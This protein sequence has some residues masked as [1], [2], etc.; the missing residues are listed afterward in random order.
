M[1]RSKWIAGFVALAMITSTG[2][3]LAKLNGRRSFDEPGV[4]VGSVP[5][6][7]ETGALAAR[8]SVILPDNVLG[9]AF[10][11]RPMSRV[12]L[13]GLPRDTTFGRR[14]Y[15]LPSR[16]PLQLTVV[17]MGSNRA[18][19]H[20]PE[21][22]LIAQNWAIV[23][24][25]RVGIPID[26]PVRYDLEANKLT[27][28]MLRKTDTGQIQKISGLYVYWFVSGKK[29]TAEPLSGMMWSIAKTLLV[30][31]TLERWSYVSCFCACLPGQEDAT[32][33]EMKEFIRASVPQFQLVPPGSTAA[34]SAQSH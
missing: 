20:Q 21:Y 28:S 1:A 32:Y 30:N 29:L 13:D 33:G 31:G 5:I 18:S 34:N 7:D 27:V 10:T 14:L 25:E 24:T 2:A 8:Q 19:I 9:Y 17:L 6:Y 23:K 11:N 3:V 22:C 16:L 12:E 26:R 4:K 15:Q